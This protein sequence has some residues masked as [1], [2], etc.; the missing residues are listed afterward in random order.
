M[1]RKTR[2]NREQLPEDD[3]EQFSKEEID[4]VQKQFSD[5]EWKILMDSPE[6]RDH[7]ERREI[8]KAQEMASALLR[9]NFK[10]AEA[11][12]RFKTVEAKRR[13]KKAERLFRLAEAEKIFN[14][15]MNKRP[16]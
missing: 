13:Q 5:S 2:S 4:K 7:W 9:G 3:A 11:T 14:L 1:K 12:R 15:L 16:D 6:F 8:I 10:D